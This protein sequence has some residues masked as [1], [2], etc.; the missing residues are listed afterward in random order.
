M[1]GAPEKNIMP[2][3]SLDTENKNYSIDIF[4]KEEENES[5]GTVASKILRSDQIVCLNNFGAR[6]IGGFL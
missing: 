3:M 6:R 4:F 2:V 5:V 1:N